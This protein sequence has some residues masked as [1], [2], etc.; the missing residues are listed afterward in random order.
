LSTIS[1]RE[2]KQ[3]LWK[4]P[5]VELDDGSEMNLRINAFAMTA[6]AD[7]EKH[8]NGMDVVGRAERK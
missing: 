7:L 5:E 6:M 1:Q 3:W 2:S 4:A 8:R